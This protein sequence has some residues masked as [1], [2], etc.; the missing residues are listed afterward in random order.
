VAAI[1]DATAS[2]LSRW[3]IAPDLVAST[4]TAEGLLDALPVT[5]ARALLPRAA[6]ARAVLPE[7]LRARGWDVDVLPVYR[8]E[9]RAVPDVGADAIVFLSSSAV[10]AYVDA[11]GAAPNALV[12]CIGPVTASTARQRGLE[13]AIEA[14]AGDVDALVGL[15]ADALGPAGGDID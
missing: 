13:V 15:V 7:G 8:T 11:T 4:A 6:V 14:R 1:G 2:A 12:A 3:R 5:P 9:A 10:D